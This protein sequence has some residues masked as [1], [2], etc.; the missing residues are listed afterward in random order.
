MSL[1]SEALDLKWDIIP[2]AVAVAVGGAV[3]ALFVA[4]AHADHPMAVMILSSVVSLTGGLY[5]VHGAVKLMGPPSAAVVARAQRAQQRETE[6]KRQAWLQAAAAFGQNAETSPME[7]RMTGSLKSIRDQAEQGLVA[8]DA[9]KAR[10]LAAI[11][12]MAACDLDDDPDQ[13][14]H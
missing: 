10:H 11:W 1:Q 4:G 14:A 9:E 5:S 6:L 3:T 2:A 7:I 12:S 8:S 13:V